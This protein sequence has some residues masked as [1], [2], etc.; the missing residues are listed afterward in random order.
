MFIGTTLPK[1]RPGKQM[2]VWA[3]SSREDQSN[4][5]SRLWLKPE[6]ML[7]PLPLT[8]YFSVPFK[9]VIWVFPHCFEWV[10]ASCT[11]EEKQRVQLRQAGQRTTP[12]THNFL[13]QN[14]SVKLLCKLCTHNFIIT[15]INYLIEYFT[16]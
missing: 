6:V 14:K 12:E 7:L 10:V 2:S 9:C 15:L 16:I 13:F 1:S 8:T 4:S 5:V 3:S 11:A